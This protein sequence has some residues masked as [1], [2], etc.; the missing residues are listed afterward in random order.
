MQ[1]YLLTQITTFL[2]HLREFFV[3]K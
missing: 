3:I 2:T 1:D